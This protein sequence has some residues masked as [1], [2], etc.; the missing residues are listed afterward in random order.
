MYVARVDM[1]RLLPHEISEVL[2]ILTCFV[3]VL[4]NGREYCVD[5]R[6]LMQ[7]S[8][9]CQQVFNLVVNRLV[10]DRVQSRTQK[11]TRKTI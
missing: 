4:I 1:P 2:P 10:A 11:C 8:V 5:D 9:L 3:R 7:V 6:S